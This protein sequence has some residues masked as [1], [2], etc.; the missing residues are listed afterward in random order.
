MNGP[1][2][3][4]ALDSCL[5]VWPDEICGLLDHDHRLGRLAEGRVL[6]NQAQLGKQAHIDIRHA[7]NDQPSADLL[8]RAQAG[9]AFYRA[10]GEK[11]CLS[12]VQVTVQHGTVVRIEVV[13]AL[14]CIE[15]RGLKGPGARVNRG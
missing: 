7:V 12:Q 8:E 14:A 13:N 4:P 10:A 5:E 3:S 11:V 9:P 1:E 15:R 6:A 2:G